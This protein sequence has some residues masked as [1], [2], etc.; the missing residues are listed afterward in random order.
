M[1]KRER[2]LFLSHRRF[3]LQALRR[4]PFVPF[5][6][7]GVAWGGATAALVGLSLLAAHRVLAVGA[8]HEV[9][10]AEDAAL[11][12]R[13]WVEVDG[14]RIH[15]LE[16]VGQA[17]DGLPVV[18]VHGLALSGRYMIPTAE[19]LARTHRVYVPDF[20]G[21]G[22][23]DKPE[24]VL[25]VSGL[26]DALAAWME[27]VGL[28][29]ALLLGNSFGCQIIGDLAARYPHL[30]GGAV[31]QGPTTPPE[32]RSWFWQ[33]IRWQQNAPNNPPSMEAVAGSDYDK[34]GYVR[35]LRTFHFS[36]QDRLEDKLPHIEAPVL[37]VRGSDDPICNQ[38]WA[39]KVTELLPKGRLEIMPDVAH[40]LVYTSGPQLAEVSLP[41]FREVERSVRG[42]TGIQN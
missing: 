23:S 30:V 11:L 1:G 37:V 17:P 10:T 16:S 38:E 42:R 3:G 33:F 35:A 36:I 12:E 6:W 40:T 25:S 18:L 31:L 24:R 32:E 22:D 28:E 21:F 8:D 2:I 4:P 19:P 9:M 34:T 5:G 39:E 7:R 29:N 27:A 13:R 14:L 41:F 20:P 26:A 15:Y